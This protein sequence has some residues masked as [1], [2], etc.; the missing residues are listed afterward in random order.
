M[1]MATSRSYSSLTR[2]EL[3]SLIQEKEEELSNLRQLLADSENSGE[4]FVRIEG[5]QLSDSVERSA[6]NSTLSS[7][8]Q[9]T[10]EGPSARPSQSDDHNGDW[11]GR[12]VKILVGE[13]KPP[14]RSPVDQLPVFKSNMASTPME[15]KVSSRGWPLPSYSPRVASRL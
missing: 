7:L 11:H 6:S 1:T 9:L 4:P 15:F 14:T 12:R 2:D 13:K 3:R 5:L 10:D 8:A